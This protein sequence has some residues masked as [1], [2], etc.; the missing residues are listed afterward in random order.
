MTKS[1][2]VAALLTAALAGC[3]KPKPPEPYDKKI[4]QAYLE[5]I[6]RGMTI[7]PCKVPE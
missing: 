3:A 7:C 2:V 6:L 4:D 1:V 5:G